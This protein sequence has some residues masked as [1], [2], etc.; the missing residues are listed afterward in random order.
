MQKVNKN[1]S[2][3]YSK[4]SARIFIYGLYA[5][6]CHAALVFLY[7]KTYQGVTQYIPTPVLSYMV[8]H[9]LM[10]LTVLFIGCFLIDYVTEKEKQSGD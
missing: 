8:E 2:P 7:A 9:T 1:Q 4:L 6:I 3:P 5:V 10:G